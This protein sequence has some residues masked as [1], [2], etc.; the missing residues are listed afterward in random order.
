M[1]KKTL[2]IYMIFFAI[3]MIDSEVPMIGQAKESFK[4]SNTMLSL[5]PMLFT[6]LMALIG[7]ILIFIISFIL[8]LLRIFLP[9][10]GFAN[11][12][13]LFFSITIKSIPNYTNELSGLIVS[14]IAG[15]AVISPV[16]EIVA[17]S[18]SIQRAFTVP[19][20]CII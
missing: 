9:G 4:I 20:L 1:R 3:R 5:L 17:E 2:P 13:P 15:D 19:V 10:P 11:I 16:M 7:V 18:T 8:T 14:S 6:V 12:F